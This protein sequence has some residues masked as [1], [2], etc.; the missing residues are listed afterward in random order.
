MNP[1]N[2]Q[3]LDRII[4]L[5]ESLGVRYSQKDT[6]DGYNIHLNNSHGF[7]SKTEDLL[8]KFCGDEAAAV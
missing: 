6:K 2:Q 7:M 1:T 5:E 3:L 8:N 4:S